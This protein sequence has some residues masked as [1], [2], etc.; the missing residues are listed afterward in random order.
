MHLY[1]EDKGFIGCDIR[2]VLFS[3]ECLWKSVTVP[4]GF[5]FTGSGPPTQGGCCWPGKK[6][7]WQESDL[8]LT[9]YLS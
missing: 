7:V 4:V 9:G 1:R 8:Q 5:I 6:A 2:Y 3:I